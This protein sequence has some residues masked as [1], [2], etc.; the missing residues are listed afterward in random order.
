MSL[1]DSGISH[2]LHLPETLER[3]AALSAALGHDGHSL[4]VAPAGNASEKGIGS[5]PVDILETS[6]NY[7]F[8]LDVPGLSKSDI[9]VTLEEEKLLIIKNNGKRKRE[10]GEEEGCCKYLRME[11]KA[12]PKFVRKFRLPGDADSSAIT[13]KCEDGVLTVTV[14]KL[15]PPEPKPKRVEVTVA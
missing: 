4:D 6:K 13:A 15:P 3:I 14:E 12:A 2:L 10:N 5:V 1:L 11:R 9:Q 8:F 7:S